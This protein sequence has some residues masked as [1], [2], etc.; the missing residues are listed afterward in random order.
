MTKPAS[1]KR[2][3][4]SWF[5]LIFLSVG[6]GVLPASAQ[7]G[8][9]NVRLSAEY[10]I[11]F[12]CPA[13]STLDPDE[14]TLW[15]LM[16]NCGDKNFSLHSFQ[17]TDGAPVNADSDF[18][19]S[20]LE[21]LDDAWIDYSTQPMAFTPDGA[22]EI[23]YTDIEIYDAHSLRLPF[24]SELVANPFV[25]LTLDKLNEIIPSYEG[26]AE[27]TAYNADHTLAA[28]TNI[29]SLHIIDLQTGNERFQIPTNHDMYDSLPYFSDDGQRLYVATWN[30]FEDVDD[31]SSTLRAY[32]LPDGDL[33]ETYDVPSSLLKISPNGQYAVVRTGDSTGESETLLVIELESG[34][35]S[36]PIQVFEPPSKVLRC[37]NREGDLSDVDF[38]TSGR[39]HIQGITWLPDSSGFFTVNS[40]G[41]EGAGGGAP[42]FFNYSRLRHYTIATD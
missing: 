35:T 3:L 42:C 7:E 13:A 33:L 18:F 23:L 9:L 16:D 1:R 39:L 31:Y 34:S 19:A 27:L 8:T 28:V 17:V 14:A 29:A 15:V 26:Y 25:I 12:D 24:N 10:D 4:I 40:Y 38:T 11:G 22:L 2:V 5:A 37:L 41:G 32:S 20:A 21:P 6:I 30:N 36:A